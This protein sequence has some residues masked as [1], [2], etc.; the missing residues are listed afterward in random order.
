MT[1]IDSLV[2]KVLVVHLVFLWDVVLGEFGQ[3]KH[4]WHDLLLLERVG[5]VDQEGDDTVSAVLVLLC[6]GKLNQCLDG[7][8][9]FHQFFLDVRVQS[10]VRQTLGSP[11]PQVPTK[12]W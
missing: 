5:H 9:V 10:Q 1:Y 7:S 4:L 12:Q 3:L 2:D 8:F 11:S 6:L